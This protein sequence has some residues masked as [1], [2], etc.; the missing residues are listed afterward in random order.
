MKQL[1]GLKLSLIKEV[2]EGSLADIKEDE[3]CMLTLDILESC[4]IVVG[5][6][7]PMIY[8]ESI[9]KINDLFQ[10]DA[11]IHWLHIH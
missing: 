10:M 3:V 7:G 6:H 2:F 5:K 8:F 1:R 4:H 11:R 9:I